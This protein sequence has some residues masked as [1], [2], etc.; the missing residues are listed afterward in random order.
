MR[1]AGTIAMRSVGRVCDLLDVVRAEAGGVSLERAAQL[2]GLPRSSA[3][4]Y[5]VA[6][7]RRG[8]VERRES[9]GVFRYRAGRRPA[10]LAADLALAL[11]EWRA[12][13]RARLVLA[14]PD[15]SGERLIVICDVAAPAGSAA[16]GAVID[17][18]PAFPAGWPA[19]PIVAA[20]PAGTV[21]VARWL[22]GPGRPCVLV[23]AV[24]QAHYRSELLH[25]LPGVA[26]RCV[27]VLTGAVR[28]G[29]PALPGS[30]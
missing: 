2:S 18:L 21:R 3:Y 28:A 4:R 8:Y 16:S 30:D 22:P 5:L 13:W 11:Q 26:A 7:E 27:A 9:H 25:E 19:T 12:R 20:G 23:V 24:P 10:S 17:G 29:D 1:Q 6:L 15:R 14:T